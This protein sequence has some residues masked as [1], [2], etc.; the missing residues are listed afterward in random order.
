MYTLC[1]DSYA[2]IFGM[3]NEVSRIKITCRVWVLDDPME[4]LYRD[5]GILLGKIILL[6]QNK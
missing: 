5:G 6:I 2:T 3:S 4:S 1:Q